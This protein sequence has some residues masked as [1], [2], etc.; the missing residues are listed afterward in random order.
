MS[1]IATESHLNPIELVGKTNHFDNFNTAMPADMHAGIIIYTIKTLSCNVNED[2][3]ELN[4]LLVYVIVNNNS[5][6]VVITTFHD[7]WSRLCRG[8]SGC[9]INVHIRY[10]RI[11]LGNAGVNLRRFET[12]C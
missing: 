3:D 4:V 5:H 2:D 7:L 8:G 9:I 11:V 1:V 12:S 6:D 10:H